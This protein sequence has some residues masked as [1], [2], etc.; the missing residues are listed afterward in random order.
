[1]GGRVRTVKTT[2]TTTTNAADRGLNRSDLAVLSAA[3]RFHYLTAA[4]VNR[5]VFPGCHDELRYAR[6]RLAR[7]VDAGLLL[8]L[9][10][11]ALPHR[12]A[13]PHVL[14]LTK[15]GRRLLGLPAVYLRP[16]EEQQKTRNLPFIYHTLATIDVV[17]AAELLCR[18]APVS[19]PRLLM[20]RELK[21][22]PS[23]VPLGSADGQAER[24]VA[25]IRTPGSSWRWGRRSRWR[26]RWSWT[27]GAKIRN[28]DGPR[29]RR[30]PPGRWAR[31]GRISRPSRSPSRW[32]PRMRCDGSSCASGPP[33]SWTGSA[34]ASL[35]RSFCSPTPIRSRSRRKS[36][37]SA[38]AGTSAHHPGAGE[39]ADPAGAAAARG[40]AGEC[41][42]Q[43]Q[44]YAG[45]G[46]TEEVWRAGG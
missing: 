17:I 29:W 34:R 43:G 6:R 42:G 40:A 3:A 37:S 18:S 4:R 5:L 44:L 28:A 41:P 12:G 26:S 14:T 46:A 38:A 19:M 35:L 22:R 15:A 45:P 23:R 39:P 10:P 13:A 8:R 31:T 27:G 30:W 24:S 1:M 32:S 11:L 36:C 7:L 16:S 21:A 2:A 9:K 33:R 25:V 20:E